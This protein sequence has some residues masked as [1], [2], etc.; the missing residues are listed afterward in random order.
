MKTS[1]I[2]SKLEPAQR[3]AIILDENMASITSE[4][5]FYAKV[6]FVQFTAYRDAGFTVDQSIQL[7]ALP[8]L[9]K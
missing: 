3:T 8:R 1:D 6:R 7:M 9:Q 2:M 4:A 5:D